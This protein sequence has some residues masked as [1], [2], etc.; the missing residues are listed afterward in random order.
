LRRTLAVAC[1]LALS[2]LAAAAPKTLTVICYHRFGVETKKDPYKIS[3][4]RLEAQLVW[5]QAQGYQSVS[6]KTL[7]KALDDPSTPLPAKALILSVDDGYK[8]GLGGAPLFE[9]Y[10]FRGVYFVNAGCLGRGSFMSWQDARDLEKA[11]HEVASHTLTHPNLGKPDEGE[12]PAQ[13]KN[14][15]GRELN[16]SRRRLEKELGHPVQA[17]AYP[18]G[19]YNPA[20]EAAARRAGYRLLFSVTDGANSME[21][22]DAGHLGRYLLMGHPSQAAFE[23]RLQ[24]E[25]AGTDFHGLEEGAL[26]LKG[27]APLALSAPAG[28]KLSVEGRELESLPG[29]LKTGFHFLVLSQGARQS[30]RMFQVAPQAWAPHFQALTEP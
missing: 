23:K 22:M 3:P 21:P 5:L 17:L 10:G 2:A 16:G 15:V 6:L 27:A 20:V 28:V 29:D 19:A 14:R 9:K 24:T 25:P 8:A 13:Y 7:G 18:F 1:L 12:S 11:G 30:K 4:E 26:I